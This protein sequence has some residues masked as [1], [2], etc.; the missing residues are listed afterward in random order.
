[1]Q[2]LGMKKD[3]KVRFYG[4]RIVGEMFI[5]LFSATFTGGVFVSTDPIAN[6]RAKTASAS[7]HHAGWKPALRF[8]IRC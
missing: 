6:Y 8:D 3:R 5:C 1:M 4:S 2:F 7:A